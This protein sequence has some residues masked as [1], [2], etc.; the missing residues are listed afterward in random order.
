MAR[1]FNESNKTSQVLFVLSVLYMVCAVVILIITLS[2]IAV[3]PGLHNNHYVL[4]GFSLASFTFS[5]FIS[6]FHLS[7]IIRRRKRKTDMPVS[8]AN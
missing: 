1:W 4:I 3:I 7:T 2:A 5:V 8:R 6:A